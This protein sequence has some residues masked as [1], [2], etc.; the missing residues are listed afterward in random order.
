[1]QTNSYHLPYKREANLSKILPGT[2]QCKLAKGNI[3]CVFGSSGPPGQHLS[4][5]SVTWSN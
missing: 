5:V 4:P 1:M 2:I 3:K